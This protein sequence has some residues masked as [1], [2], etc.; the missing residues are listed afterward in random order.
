MGK[1]ERQSQSVAVSPCAC[2][3]VIFKG[4]RA[5]P[6]TCQV[7]IDGMTGQFPVLASGIV[8]I[9]VLII[10]SARN[11]SRLPFGTMGGPSRVAHFLHNSAQNPPKNVDL[12]QICL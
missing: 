1:E 10:S 11:G 8:L 7:A 4:S 5:V 2:Q 12:F 6:G 3:Q 9:A